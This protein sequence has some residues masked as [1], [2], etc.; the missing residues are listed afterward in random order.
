M[1]GL[2]GMAKIGESHRLADLM[3]LQIQQRKKIKIKLRS[4]NIINPPALQ[5][6]ALFRFKQT[7]CDTESTILQGG[8]ITD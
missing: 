7:L 5:S 8:L 1:A 2:N 6:C 4:N 3:R